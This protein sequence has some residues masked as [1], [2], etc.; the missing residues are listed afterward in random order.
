MRDARALR[1]RS[2]TSYPEDQMRASRTIASI[3]LAVIAAFVVLGAPATARANVITD[4]DER[5][6]ILLNPTAP[7]NWNASGLEKPLRQRCWRRVRTMVRM[8]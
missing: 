6:I 2:R 3:P 8:H 5:A 4:W 7:Q 1:R